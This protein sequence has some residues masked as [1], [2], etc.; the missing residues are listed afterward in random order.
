MSERNKW[1]GAMSRRWRAHFEPLLPLPCSKCGKPVL[2]GQPWDV[3]HLVPREFGGLELGADNLW[4]AHRSCNR[5]A[6]GR[7]RA[8]L[9]NRGRQSKQNDGAQL[10]S[11]GIRW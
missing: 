10:A 5:S 3:D 11:D 6:G 1:T 2:P 9:T 8:K 7:R 4:P